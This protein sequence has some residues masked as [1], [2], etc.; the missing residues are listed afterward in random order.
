MVELEKERNKWRSKFNIANH[1]L[2]G[3][4][5]ALNSDY[6]Q[7]LQLQQK[8]MADMFQTALKENFGAL[9]GDAVC[10]PTFWFC[11]PTTF[12]PQLGSNLAPQ[13]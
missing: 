2:K 3:V 13:A 9:R 11:L 8:Q 5:Q 7:D 6:T 10:G 12:L 1:K 4:K